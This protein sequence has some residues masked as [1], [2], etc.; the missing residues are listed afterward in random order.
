VREERI[1]ERN[2]YNGKI[3]EGIIQNGKK[4]RRRVE[5]P[6]RRLQEWKK[7]RRSEREHGRKVGRK[8]EMKTAGE[9]DMY[10]ALLGRHFRFKMQIPPFT[11]CLTSFAIN[12]SVFL[13][14]SMLFLQL[15]SL[16]QSDSIST[17]TTGHA[18]P[19]HL[20]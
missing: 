16:L 1:A 2:E 14:I 17:D 12:M 13:H 7:G 20:I 4:E 15:M 11:E 10:S 6:E 8:A 3:K 9:H 18:H 19:L 5:G